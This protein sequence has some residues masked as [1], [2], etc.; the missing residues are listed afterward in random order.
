MQFMLK[1]QVYTNRLFG[2][3]AMNHSEKTELSLGR[4][5][6]AVPAE[7]R[8]YVL[9]LFDISETKKY[10]ILTKLLRRYAYRIQKS[11][12]E[13][14]LHNSEYKELVSNI[15]KLMSSSR[16]YNKED[17]VRIYRISGSCTVLVFGMCAVDHL[18]VEENLFF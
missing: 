2:F 4:I 15:E 7:N 17:N 18:E 3:Q 14:Y 6:G 13:A 8:Y 16:Y 9:I 12:Y 11:V 5:T 1:T 10:T